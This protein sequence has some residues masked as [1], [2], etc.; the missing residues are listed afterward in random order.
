MIAS[1]LLVSALAGPASDS[2]LALDRTGIEW[3]VPFTEAR[4]AAR[5]G[6]RLLFIKPVAFGTTPSGCW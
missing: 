2:P 4:D 5:E 6:G 3:V 1:L